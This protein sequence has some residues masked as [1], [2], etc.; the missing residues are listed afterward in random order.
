MRFLA[1]G[2]MALI[3]TLA[4][5]SGSYDFCVIRIGA[6]TNVFHSRF[7][8][9]DIDPGKEPARILTMAKFR[10]ADTQSMQ[11]TDYS[12]SGCPGEVITEFSVSASPDDLQRFVSQAGTDPASAAITALSIVSGASVDVV[13]A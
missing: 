10:T 8:F 12:Q 11:I 7:T 9:G 13:K 6:S 5:A 1:L 3:T 2:L 4:H